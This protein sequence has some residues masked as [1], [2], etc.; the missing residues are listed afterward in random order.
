MNIET[1]P[2]HSDH[3]A[4]FSTHTLVTDHHKTLRFKPSFLG[5]L[6]PLL[7]KCLGVLGLIYGVFPVF[8]SDGFTLFVIVL[9]GVSFACIG[10]WMEKSIAR[11]RVFHLDRQE[12]EFPSNPTS[13]S[14]ETKIVKFGEVYALQ[15]VQKTVHGDE[16]N[17]K[18]FELNLVLKDASRWNIMDHG[19]GEQLLREAQQIAQYLGCKIIVDANLSTQPTMMSPTAAS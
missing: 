2:L 7:F 18:S 11:E 6:F 16:T 13:L 19:G 15:I 8:T 12:V 5:S 9:A 3:G 14:T 17:F 4:S 1:G 10:I